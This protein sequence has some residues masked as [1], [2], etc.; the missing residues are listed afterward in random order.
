MGCEDVRTSLMLGLALDDG[1][2]RHVTM[3]TSCR[4]EA[5]AV[6]AVAAALA[7]HR[8]PAPSQALR[9]RVLDAAAPLLD[10]RARAVITPDWGA[11][12]RALGAA[13][14]PLPL[15]ALAQGY[16]VNLLYRVLTTLLPGPVG[17]YLVFNYVALVAL[18]A[19][20]TYAAIP[21]VAAR[22]AEARHA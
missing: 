2:A 22:Q 3:C 5:P 15:I 9:A 1:A 13:L 20:I 16:V 8:A 10:R 19:T 11:V 18:L 21:V 7:A 14:L 4:A 17:A 12:A 6:R